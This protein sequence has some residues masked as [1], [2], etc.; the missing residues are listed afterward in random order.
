MSPL[1]NNRIIIGTILLGI[2]FS[3]YQILTIGKLVEKAKLHFEN[4]EIHS[5]KKRVGKLELELKNNG[6]NS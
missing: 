6:I 5:L 3:T 2:L 4:Q 1:E